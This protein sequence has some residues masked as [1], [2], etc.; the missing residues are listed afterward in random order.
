MFTESVE[1]FIRNDEHFH[2]NEKVAT[3]E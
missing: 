1:K 2:S 3:F